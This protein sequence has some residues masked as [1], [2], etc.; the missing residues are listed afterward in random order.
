MTFLGLKEIVASLPYLLKVGLTFSVTLTAL[1]AV[2]GLM[3][4]TLL[5]LCRMSPSRLLSVP[6]TL[7]VNGMRSV[8]L[9]LVIFCSIS[10]RPTSAPGS[11]IRLRLSRLVLIVPLSSRSRFSSRRTF[12]RS[13]APASSPLQ[14]DR[15]RRVSRSALLIDRR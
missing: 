14:G 9:L 7:F 2:F 1:A 10:S 15:C 13:C 3:L 11:C 4:G 8:P 5:A 6:A 12:A